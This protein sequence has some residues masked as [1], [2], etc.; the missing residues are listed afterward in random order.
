MS[1]NSELRLRGRGG[2]ACGQCSEVE[3][4][5]KERTAPARALCRITSMGA[6]TAM[7]ESMSRWFAK[8]RE[9]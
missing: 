2:E 1:K 3:G 4:C 8:C 9:F 5:K 7:N 6:Q